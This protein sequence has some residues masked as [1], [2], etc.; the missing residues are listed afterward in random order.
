LG[1]V[2]G[3]REAALVTDDNPIEWKGCMDALL[4]LITMLAFH[5]RIGLAVLFALISAVFLATNIS[6]FTG[7]HGV[8]L[9]IFSFGAGLIWE[10]APRSPKAGGNE[11]PRG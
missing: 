7:W 9:V 3:P 4:E 8:L 11:E 10:S 2:G 5:W 6:W 1:D